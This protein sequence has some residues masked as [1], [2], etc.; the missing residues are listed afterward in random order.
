M[1]MYIGLMLILPIIPMMTR[2]TSR[3]RIL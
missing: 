3:R 1:L 2:M